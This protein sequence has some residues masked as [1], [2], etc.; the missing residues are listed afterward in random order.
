M[1]IAK[2][3]E[4]SSCQKKKKQKGEKIHRKEIGS[5]AKPVGTIEGRI[6]R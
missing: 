1:G 3:D 4:E 2:V 6:L 5:V